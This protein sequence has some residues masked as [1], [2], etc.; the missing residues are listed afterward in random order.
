MVEA[1]K[2]PGTAPKIE[3]KTDGT[4]VTLSTGGQGSTGNSRL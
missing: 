3:S 4:T 2:A 1:P